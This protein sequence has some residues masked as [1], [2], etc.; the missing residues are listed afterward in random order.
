MSGAGPSLIALVPSS[1]LTAAAQAAEE[2]VP[3]G[4]RV[5]T[6]G[7]DREGAQVG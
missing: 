3:E 6:P 2:L 1:G 5:L 7:W 4:W